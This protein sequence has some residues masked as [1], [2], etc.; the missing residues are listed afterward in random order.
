MARVDGSRWRDRRED[1]DLSQGEAAERLRMP[2]QSLRQIETVKD[3]PVS[4]RVIKR[5]ARL[6]LCTPEWLQGMEDT[7]PAPPTPEQPKPKREPAGEPTAPAPRRDG[8]DNRRGPARADL[9]EAS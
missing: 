8:K 9:A 2:Q 3:R 4:T 1:F 5:A 6:Y 7:P